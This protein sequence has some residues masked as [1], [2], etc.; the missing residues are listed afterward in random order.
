MKADDLQKTYDVI[1]N[2][3]MKLRQWRPLINLLVENVDSSVQ[4][5]F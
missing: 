3:A 5:I 2:E 1:E 4:F